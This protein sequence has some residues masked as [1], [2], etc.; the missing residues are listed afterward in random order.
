MLCSAERAIRT[1]VV[2]IDSGRRDPVVRTLKDL[3]TTLGFDLEM[4]LVPNEEHDRTLEATLPALE[5]G[6]RA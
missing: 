3:L 1:T 4:R 5:P 6:G 2:E